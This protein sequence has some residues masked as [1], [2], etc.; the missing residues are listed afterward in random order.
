M[1][2]LLCDET[3][4]YSPVTT[5][6]DYIVESHCASFGMSKEDNEQALSICL[7]EEVIYIP[8]PNYIEYLWSNNLIISRFKSIQWFIKVS[9]NF[10]IY[11][12]TTT[13]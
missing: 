9:L 1:E 7:E 8:Q 2:S 12:E 6:K 4:L 10:Y 5:F 11:R 13:L 3:W